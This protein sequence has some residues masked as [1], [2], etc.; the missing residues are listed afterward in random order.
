[1]ATGKYEQWLTPAGLGK[2][3]AWARDGLTD[4][5]LAKKMG[6]TRKTLYEWLKKHGDICDS[7]TRGRGGAREQ[8]ENSL[9][10]RALGYTATVMEPVKLRTRLFNEEKGKFEE[11]ETVEMYP[12]EIHIPP[13]VRAASMWL[14]NRERDRWAEHPAPVDGQREAVTV[15]V[16]L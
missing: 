8:I 10:K 2:I 7:L 5:Q 14:T 16:D 6:V 1:M 12:R 4:E 15:E 9:Y 13:D 11:R 3:E